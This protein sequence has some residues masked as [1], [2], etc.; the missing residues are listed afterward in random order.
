MWPRHADR[1]AVEVPI[2]EAAA[3][4]DENE[5]LLRLKPD[6]VTVEKTFKEDLRPGDVLV[7]S[8]VRGLLD[9]F[10]WNPADRLPVVDVSLSGHGLPL[11]ASSLLRLCGVSASGSID[12]ALG[13]D[14]DGEDLDD[15]QRAA[16]V[17][18]ILETVAATIP[19]GW[20]PDEWRDFLK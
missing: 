16:A 7:L 3:A 6:R 5:P 11:D 2:G 8:S 12:R 4:F 14:A 15:E 17:D 1:E 20:Q 18:R 13:P 10:G 9:E 19:A